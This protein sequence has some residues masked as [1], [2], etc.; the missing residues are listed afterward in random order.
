M[1]INRLI[2]GFTK[3]DALY[4][5]YTNSI[6]QVMLGIIPCNVKLVVEPIML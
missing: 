5:E 3:I 1:Q 4:Y 2:G 6:N